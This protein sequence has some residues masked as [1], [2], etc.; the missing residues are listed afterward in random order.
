ML[1][2]CAVFNCGNCAD[3]QKDKSDYRFPSIVKNNDPTDSEHK[4]HKRKI[5]N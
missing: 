4:L 2:F 5:E 1:S 3:K